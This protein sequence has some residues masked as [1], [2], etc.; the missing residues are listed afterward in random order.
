MKYDYWLHCVEG[1][2]TVKIHKLLEFGVDAQELYNM[3]ERQLE[4]LIFLQPKDRKNIL[5]SKANWKLEEKMWEL[6]KKEIQFTTLNQGNYPAKLKYYKDAPFGLFWKGKLPEAEKLSVAIVGARNCSTYG[7]TVATQIGK[8]LAQAGIQVISGLARG[9][10][11]FGQQ[12]ALRGNGT[13]YGVLGCGADICYPKENISLF[14]DVIES[15]GILTEYPP[16]MEP[17]PG[18]FPMRN[19][20]I[21][22]LSDVLLVVEAKARSGSLITA[23]FA[24][25]QGKEVYAVPGPINSI[26]SAGCHKLMKQGAGIFTSTKELLFELRFQSSLPQNIIEDDKVSLEKE[27]IIVYSYIA[28]LPKNVEIIQAESGFEIQKLRGILVTLQ[29]KGYISEVGKNQYIRT[30]M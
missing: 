11:S 9:I 1:M 23:D 3:N 28:L 15:G 5:V 29:L 24:M 22:G 7:K 18:F 14:M 8:E 17:L 25:E 27:E 13:T 2:G 19:R 16:G 10:D 26:L 6:A 4:Q 20:I 21:S 12:G 30:M